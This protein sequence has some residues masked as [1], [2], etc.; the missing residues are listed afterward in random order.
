[1]LN[2]WFGEEHITLAIG[3]IT[4]YGVRIL[5]ALLV[6]LVGLWGA[7]LVRSTIRHAMERNNVDPTLIGFVSKLVY[8]ALLVAVVI[9]AISQ[10]GIE[11]TSFI[12]MLGAAGLAIGLA[13][14][15]SLS[16]FASGVLLILFRPMR[17]GDFVDIGGVMGTVVEVGILSTR[18]RTP[19]NKGITVP[20]SQIMGTHIVNFNAYPT[21]RLELVFGIGYD[22][23]FERAKAILTEIVEADPRCLADPP[24]QIR[25]NKLGESSVD[26]VVR[27]WV[28]SANYWPVHFDMQERVKQ[29]FDA[30]GI[31]IPYPQRD[32]HLHRVP[33]GD[34]P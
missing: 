1:M 30:E 27:P 9:A 18:L 28:E 12:A 3:Y 26:I 19:D 8:Y 33:S 32:V 10:V 16:N 25:V 31:T 2:D 14:Q 5:V 7:S 24:P 20:N 17:V 23:D 22:D 6:L 15:G 21:R 34:T 4:L 13:L 11:T 29:R